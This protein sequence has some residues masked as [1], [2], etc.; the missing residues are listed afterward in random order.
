MKSR[1]LISEFNGA[2]RPIIRTSDGPRRRVAASSASRRSRPRVL[3]ADLNRSEST[4]EGPSGTRDSQ[5][6][7][8]AER[9]S[10]RFRKPQRQQIATLSPFVM[11]ATRKAAH[12]V[13]ATIADFRL[14]E[15]LCHRSE[16]EL[17]RIESLARILNAS[18]QRSAIALQLARYLQAIVF[19]TTVHDDVGDGFLKAKLNRE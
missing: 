4:A 13:D 9:W 10:V 12:Q 2:A 7:P 6:A 15:R 19:W 18:H 11:H 8:E 14:L 16:R 17:G 3:G 5:I 1:R